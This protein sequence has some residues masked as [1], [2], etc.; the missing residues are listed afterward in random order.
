MKV[1]RIFDLSLLCLNWFP[2][3]Q[4]SKNMSSAERLAVVMKSAA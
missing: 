2:V 1:L 3:S 4:V